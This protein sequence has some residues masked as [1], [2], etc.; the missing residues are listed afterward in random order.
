M[1][2]VIYS[3][4]FLSVVNVICAQ[5]NKHY[6]SIDAGLG[7]NSEG[8]VMQLIRQNI[9]LHISNGLY[10]QLSYSALDGQEPI[11]KIIEQTVTN[12]AAGNMMQIQSLHLGFRKYLQ[13]GNNKFISAAISGHYKRSSE[14]QLI[15]TA[16]DEMGRIIDLETINGYA[17]YSGLSFDLNLQ[18]HIHVKD[19][20][21]LS[22]SASYFHDPAIVIAGASCQFYFNI[23]SKK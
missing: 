2:T 19:Y 13:F 12:N 1:R 9:G 4:I 18:Y 20:L 8:L 7:A 10:A 14:F 3:I 6:V 21:G 16:L 5:D 23:I 17:T 22:L 11:S 15:Q